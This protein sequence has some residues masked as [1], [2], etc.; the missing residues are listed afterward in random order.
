MKILVIGSGGRE[1]A[2]VWKLA[3]SPSVTQVYAIPGNPGMARLARCLPG[4]DYLA[5]AREVA[6][7]LTV[8]GPEAPWSAVWWT[9]FVPKAGKSSGPRLRPLA[10]KGARFLQRTFCGKETSRL[11]PS[12]PP[13]TR[14]KPARPSIASACP[15][16]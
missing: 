1:H 3:Q 9:H 14:P 16:S 2:L 15:W 7:D 11:L 13:T 8:V 4:T 12:S 10:W 6:A 5:A